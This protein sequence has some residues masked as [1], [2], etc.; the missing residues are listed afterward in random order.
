MKSLN[1]LQPCFNKLRLSLDLHLLLNPHTTLT[2]AQSRPVSALS[3]RLGVTNVLFD[4]A[5]QHIR[6]AETGETGAG[7]GGDVARIGSTAGWF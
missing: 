4:V 2:S 1:M 7:Q 3:L 6:D 5:E